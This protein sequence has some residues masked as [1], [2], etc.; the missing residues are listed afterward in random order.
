[1]NSKIPS[2][3]LAIILSIVFYNVIK[4]NNIIILN[5]I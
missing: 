1:M 4:L 2:V 3:I 5:K